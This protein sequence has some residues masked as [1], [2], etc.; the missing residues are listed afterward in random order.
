MKLIIHIGTEKTGTTSIQELF[1][2]NR[3]FLIH[4]GYYYLRSPGE[5]NHRALAAYGMPRQRFDDFLINNG[6]DDTEKRL[7]FDSEVAENLARELADLPANIHTVITSSEHFHSRCGD[8]PGIERLASLLRPYFS[9]FEILVYLRPQIDVAI[10]LYSTALKV[11]ATHDFNASFLRRWCT[12]KNYYYNYAALLNNW[13][14]VFGQ[15]AIRPHIFDRRE[16]VDGDLFSDILQACGIAT[17]MNGMTI[18]RPAPLNESLNPFGQLLLRECNRSFPK[19]SENL[20]SRTEARHLRDEI[21]RHCSGSSSI[22]SK[23]AEDIQNA[24]AT[25]N[26]KVCQRWF[27]GRKSLFAFSPTKYSAPQIQ[28]GEAEEACVRAIYVRFPQES[29]NKEDVDAIRDAALMLERSNL[30]LSRQLME[31]AARLRPNGVFIRKK[32]QEY[33]RVLAKRGG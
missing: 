11:G 31:I 25:V 16:F 24:F 28:L 2:I 32:L 12:P 22:D 4:Q 14:T 6:I 10:S 8:R 15:R 9:E 3:E 19:S 1:H 33:D 21:V 29:S 5:R 26:N 17:S 20:S 18:E 27:A 13:A 30:E 23:L 7:K